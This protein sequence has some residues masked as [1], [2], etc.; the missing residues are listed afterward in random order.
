MK[1]TSFMASSAGRWLRII[2]GAALVVAGFII[3]DIGGII[4][5]IVGLVALVAGATDTCV[6][7]PLFGQSFKGGVIRKE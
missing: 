2:V 1:F 7:A 4:L 5:S 3:G 6:F